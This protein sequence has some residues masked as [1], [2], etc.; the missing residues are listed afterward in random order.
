MYISKYPSF[1]QFYFQFRTGLRQKL[2][3]QVDSILR[4][5]EFESRQSVHF[6]A[7]IVLKRT[8]TKKKRPVKKRIKTFNV[9]VVEW[10]KV[11]G[12]N[13]TEVHNFSAKIVLKRTK[14]KKKRPA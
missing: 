1:V 13:P 2:G 6:S 7:K 3:D 12:S 4:Q 9:A 5:S 8:K 11:T 10:L 14:T